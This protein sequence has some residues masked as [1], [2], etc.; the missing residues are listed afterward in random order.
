MWNKGENSQPQGR[1]LNYR[2]EFSIFVTHYPKFTPLNGLLKWFN[3]LI[4]E[5]F[6]NELHF[7][8]KTIL[9][10]GITFDVQDK[11]EFQEI[12]S[13]NGEKI[14]DDSNETPIWILSLPGPLTYLA[15]TFNVIFSLFKN[16]FIDRS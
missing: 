15:E 6:G 11:E 8:N 2:K 1:S 12:L 7:Q 13:L 4:K 10:D 14:K 3:L 16:Q 9:K 5:R